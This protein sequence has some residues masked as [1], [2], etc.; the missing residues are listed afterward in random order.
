[1]WFSIIS[2]L[3]CFAIATALFTPELRDFKAYREFS[4]YFLFEGFWSLISFVVN[5]VWPGSTVMLWVQFIGSLIFGLYILVRLYTCF[6]KKHFENNSSNI[7]K[8]S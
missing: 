6:F 4:F 7:D 5:E 2:S 1:M 3:V 8:K